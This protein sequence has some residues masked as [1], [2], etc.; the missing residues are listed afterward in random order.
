M[1][2]K[3]LVSV[4]M[5]TYNDCP[6]YIYASL[7]SIINQTYENIEILVVDDSTDK[8]TKEAIDSFKNDNRVFI[9]REDQPLGF[10]ASLNKGLDSAKGD[11]IVRMDGDDISDIHRIEKQICFFNENKKADVV[12][13]QINI[14]DSKGNI[15]GHRNYPIKGIKLLM[16]FLIRS[17]LAHPATAFKKS[18]IDAGYRYDAKLQKAEDL[19]FWIRLYIAGYHFY[20]LPETLLDY[21]VEADFL[22]KRVIDPSQEKNVIQVRRKNFTLKR[23]VFSVLSVFFSFVRQVTPNIF[24]KSQ[25]LKE[26]QCNN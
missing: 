3:P 13:A 26:N 7:N 6:E 25:Y 23:P 14:I 1:T 5:A 4:I 11:Y 21:R 16:F 15:T 24:K 8:A 18:I 2:D 17:P 20:N 10:V 12:G 22:D 19:D 9:Y